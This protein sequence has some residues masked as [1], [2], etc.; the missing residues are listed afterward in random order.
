MSSI[1]H[2]KRITVESYYEGSIAS[3]R[4]EVEVSIFSTKTE[5]LKEVIQAM[6]VISSG[7]TSKLNLEIGVDKLGR[8]RLIK[9]WSI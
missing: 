3:T 5:I 2:G 7:E 1:Q 6:S 4:Q 8:Y 9:R